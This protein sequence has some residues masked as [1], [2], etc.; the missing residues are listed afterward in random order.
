VQTAEVV[1]AER[2]DRAAAPAARR[3]KSYREVRS[4]LPRT[5]RRSAGRHFPRSS[6]ARFVTYTTPHN[7][8]AFRETR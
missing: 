1:Q 5:V 6:A 8:N 4:L 7:E 2:P 3:R